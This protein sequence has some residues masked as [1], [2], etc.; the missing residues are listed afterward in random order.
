MRRE[1]DLKTLDRR[2]DR[3]LYNQ[4]VVNYAVVFRRSDVF[5]RSKNRG[6]AAVRVTEREGVDDDLAGEFALKN[7]AVNS[8][9]AP[10]RDYWIRT[11]QNLCSLECVIIFFHPRKISKIQ[12]APLCFNKL[13]EVSK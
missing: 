10:L 6:N 4:V 3:A 1:R 2:C 5:R 11:I 12:A 13:L 9:V 8:V 7:V